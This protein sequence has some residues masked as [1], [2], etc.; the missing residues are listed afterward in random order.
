M[1]SIVLDAS[2]Q[3]IPAYKDSNK[4]VEKRVA[5]L[6]G[7]MTLREKIAQLSHLH[8]H[9]LYNGQEV[10]F[11]KLSDAA[12]DVSYGCIEGFNLTGR[13][14]RRAFH[15]IQKY[16]VEKTRLGIPVFTVTESLHG[17]VHDGSTIFPQTVAV[18][19]TFNVE[20]AYQMTK[21]IAAE[22]RSQG[23]IQTLSPGLDVVRD[24]RWG[25]VEESFSED[26]WLV[27]QM[28]IAQVRG[29]LD[30][31]ISP[32]LKPFGPGGA[33]LGGL[34]L[35][36]VESGERDVRNIHI[37]PYEMV[38]KN[39]AVKAVMSSYNSW[40]GIPN[41][42]SSYLLT[43][44]LRGEWGFE[45]YVYSDWGAVSMLKDFQ[46]TAKNDGD[47]AI[48]ALTAGLDLEASSSCYW[49]LEQ[50]IAQGKFDE[51]YVD[52]AV[53]RILRVKFELGLFENPYQGSDMSG[54]TMR[55][56]EAVELSRRIADESIVLVK[57][58]NNLLPL[59]LNK[60]KSLAVIGPN[61]NQVQFGDYTWSRSNSDGVTPLEGL[62]KQIGN[63]LKINYAP[64]CDLT[65]DDVSGFDEAIAVAKASDIVAMFIG[66]SSASLAR[67]YSDATCGEG[68]DLSSLDLTGVQ[69]ELVK[70]VYATGKPVVVVL[71][72]GKPFSIPWLK[73]KIPA[74]VV[75]WYGGEKSGDAIADMLLGKT[76]PSAK[77]PFSFPQSVGHLPVFYNHLPT[78]KGFYRRPGQPNRPG[79]DYVFSSPAPLWS[80]GHGLSYTTFE[81]VDAKYSSD[82]L[83][84]TDTLTIKVSLKNSGNMQ[85]KEVVQLYVKDIVSSVVTP[86]KQLKAFAKPFLKPGET[87]EVI[88]RLAMQELALYDS[89]LKRIVEEGEYE[90]QIGTASDNIRLKKTIVVGEKQSAI[91]VNKLSDKE[92]DVSE[93]INNPGRKIKVSGC[94]RDVQATPVGGIEIKSNYSGKKAVSVK[95]GK[96]SIETVENDI[97]TISAQG[98]ET[99]H[100][101]VDKKNS[102]NIKLNYSHD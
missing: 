101:K 82:L 51:K 34:N 86:V 89:D 3:N 24:L 7:R 97:L 38:V 77:L 73:E 47:A 9:Q 27:G 5:D 74:I 48:Q 11:Q 76:N 32:M 56:E 19:S 30:G 81:Y 23:V 25:R 78:D 63:S 20:L 42:A 69:E 33:P 14:V 52:L 45:G 21:A 28:G 90:I 26:P 44:I 22:L 80:F 17:S 53:S 50:L 96:Y 36:S 41:S 68:F 18:G 83:Y 13:N 8:G 94:I 58:E 55:T 10:D 67:D 57:N 95:D 16:M 88:L 98:F 1:V 84:P 37:K 54:V 49:A 46:H 31:G 39:T 65:T 64:G 29:Y 43:D 72:T 40:N 92:F 85:G 71:V 6:L 93:I 79:R 66:S 4:P 61:A 99:I 35:A 62:K 12:G 15:V 70:K 91:P 100:V 102:I 87:Q 2:A 75:Q 59:D 60:I